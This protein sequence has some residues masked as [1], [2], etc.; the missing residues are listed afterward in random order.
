MA[1]L[2]PVMEVVLV[3]R[4]LILKLADVPATT[5]NVAV[6]VFVPPGSVLLAGMVARGELV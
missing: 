4:A 2:V 3:S 1:A 6:N 5:V